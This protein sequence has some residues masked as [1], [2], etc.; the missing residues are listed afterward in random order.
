MVTGGGGARVAMAA[1]SVLSAA[2]VNVFLLWVL[3]R[4][5]RAQ[6]FSFPFLQPE[7]CGHSQYFDISALSCV[8]CGAN[9]R[10]DAG[11]ETVQGG[12]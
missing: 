8:P 9:Q 6:T 2:A 12:P 4:V 11:G 5:S 3:P 7:S 10:R 1:W